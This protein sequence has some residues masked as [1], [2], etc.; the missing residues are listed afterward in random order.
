MVGIVQS[1]AIWL[2]AWLCH[3]PRG[4]HDRALDVGN[5]VRKECPVAELKLDWITNAREVSRRCMRSCVGDEFL[6]APIGTVAVEAANARLQILAESERGL[7]VRARKAALERK[8]TLNARD[9]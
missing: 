2:N 5:F 4:S 1:P 8:H 3:L 6:K 7:A 9:G